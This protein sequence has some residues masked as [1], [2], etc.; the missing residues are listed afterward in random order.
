MSARAFRTASIDTRP[1]S[2]V[3]GRLSLAC[4][5]RGLG[6][7]RYL[8]AGGIPPGTVDGHA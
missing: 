4:C 1:L 7:I 2:A 5:V 3:S 6:L 8:R